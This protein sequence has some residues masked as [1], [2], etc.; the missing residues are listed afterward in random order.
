[1]RPSRRTTKAKPKLNKREVVFELNNKLEDFKLY[2]QDTLFYLHW[3]PDMWLDTGFYDLLELK[4]AKKPEEREQD[5]MQML[6][7]LGLM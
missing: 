6:Q 5:P 4:T 2:G 7:S 3:T 1:M